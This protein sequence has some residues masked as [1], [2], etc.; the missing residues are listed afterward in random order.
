[1]NFDYDKEIVSDL[2]IH[3]LLKWISALHG[4]MASNGLLPDGI[5]SELHLQMM[6]LAKAAD[7]V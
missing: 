3:D 6:L 7:H 5:S 4:E 2:S 1:M